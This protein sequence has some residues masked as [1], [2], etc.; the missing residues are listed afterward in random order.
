MFRH[1]SVIR[2]PFRHPQT[3]FII[4]RTFIRSG[5]P[6]RESPNVQQSIPPRV[7]WHA[8]ASVHR[9]APPAILPQVDHYTDFNAKS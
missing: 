2:H 4:S 1:P 5:S 3:S 9:A 7:T 8:I 6:S